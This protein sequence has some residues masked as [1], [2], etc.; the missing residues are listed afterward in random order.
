[1]ALSTKSPSTRAALASPSVLLRVATAEDCFSV[2]ARVNEEARL[3]ILHAVGPGMTPGEA[4]DDQRLKN[5][6]TLVGC[7]DGSPEAIFGCIQVEGRP[8]RPW[9]I[10]TERMM[11][12]PFL[13]TRSA[14][15]LVSHWRSR[16]GSL[17]SEVPTGARAIRWLELLGFDIDAPVEAQCADGTVNLYHPFRI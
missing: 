6:G 12:Y 3:E 2:G 8:A 13:L 14:K 7:L 1:M 11:R 16:F 15:G 17:A 4:L 5:P 9:Y 10:G